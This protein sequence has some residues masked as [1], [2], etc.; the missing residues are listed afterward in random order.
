MALACVTHTVSQAFLRKTTTLSSGHSQRAGDGRA[1]DPQQGAIARPRF[2]PIECGF[3]WLFIAGIAWVPFWYG[4][5]DWLAW[6]I[7]AMIFPG[8]AALHEISLLVRRK[9]HAVSISY[10]AAPAALF[11]GVILWVG[12]QIW[13]GCPLTSSIRSGL[14]PTMPL[15]IGSRV[16]SVSIVI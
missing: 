14:W 15:G 3:F 5:N 8:L 16:V 7:N 10:I 6:G 9:S 12:L 1:G 4:S 2:E 11:T 13:S